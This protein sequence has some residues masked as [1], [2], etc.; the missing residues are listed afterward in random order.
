MTFNYANAPAQRDFSDLI[1]HG[2]LA[3]AILKVDPFNLDQGL[4]ETP[5]K[6]TDSRFLNV[7]LTICSG[8]HDKR[9]LFTR[10]GTGGSEKYINMGRSAIKA[11]LEVGRGAN[12][13]NN[14]NAYVLQGGDR[15]NY[16]ELDGLKVAIKIKEE[17]A[18]G[19]FP[20]KNDVDV[21]LSPVDD[22]TSKDFARLLAGDTEPK[23]K[24]SGTG[25]G[26]PAWG[27]GGTGT[28]PAPSAPAAP[29]WQSTPPTAAQPTQAAKP[30]WLP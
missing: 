21:W 22:V 16:M 6:T 25:G 29:A 14:P 8:R 13:T 20:P 27:G 28:V 10:I 18:Q 9:K 5:S 15:P 23:V 19:D 1:P 7:E 17:K 11:I 26:S 2:T 4:I 12:A 30:A 3:W 24:V